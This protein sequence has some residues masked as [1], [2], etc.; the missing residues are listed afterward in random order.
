MLPGAETR[1]EVAN[2]L[3]RTVAVLEE[4]YKADRFKT[5]RPYTTSAGVTL[6]SIE[7]ALFFNLYHEGLHMGTILS[8]LKVC[9]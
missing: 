4:D 1:K 5:Y 8:L 6:K 3:I 7:D 9:S 2:A